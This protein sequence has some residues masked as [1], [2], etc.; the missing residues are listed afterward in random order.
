MENF[1]N[2]ESNESQ[3]VIGRLRMNGCISFRDWLD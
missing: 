2:L 3:S 1:P